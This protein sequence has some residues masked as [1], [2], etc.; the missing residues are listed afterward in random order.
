MFLR[1][2]NILNYYYYYYLKF[3]NHGY[4]MRQYSL[5]T[6]SPGVMMQMLA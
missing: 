2:I 3:N 4:Y 1:Y 6:L 5:E